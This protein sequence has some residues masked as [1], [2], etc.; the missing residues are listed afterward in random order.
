ME[1]SYIF[2]STNKKLLKME[3]IIK[4]NK[5]D[6][7]IIFYNEEGEIHRS[8]DKPAVIRFRETSEVYRNGELITDYDELTMFV[9][10]ELEYYVNGQ[11]HR[12]GDKPA[13]IWYD[14]SKEYYM[15]GKL[16]REGDKPAVIGSKG[17]KEYWMNGE[18]HRDGDQPAIIHPDGTKLY[19]VNG[20]LHR[21]GG[22][23][24]VIGFFR[25]EYREEYWMNGKEYYPLKWK[26]Q[27]IKGILGKIKNLFRIL[28]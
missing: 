21:D 22:K 12:E 7:E 4:I 3:E 1:I 15:N 5:N 8:G 25:E 10:C 23:P 18:R 6:N 24:A 27:K 9:S 13:I 14:G 11:L 17:Y 2:V 16:H 28:K 26:G 20:L 19:Y